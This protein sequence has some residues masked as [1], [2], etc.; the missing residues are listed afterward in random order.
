MKTTTATEGSGSRLMAVFSAWEEAAFGRNVP[1]MMILVRVCRRATIDF[2]E[3]VPSRMGPLDWRVVPDV[4][5]KSAY[6][7]LFSDD[8]QFGDLNTV[9]GFFGTDISA[10][11]V[12]IMQAAI[13]HQMIPLDDYASVSRAVSMKEERERENVD[14]PD[15]DDE[16]D[17]AGRCASGG[18]STSDA[19]G[20]TARGAS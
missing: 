1:E 7:W 11:R 10:V 2:L 8:Q 9:C 15:G 19:R 4:H 5:R 3:P 13:E 18:R 17:D 14:G 20:A 6:E 12:L 16:A